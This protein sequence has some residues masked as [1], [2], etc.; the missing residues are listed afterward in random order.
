M[1][2]DSVYQNENCFI[3]ISSSFDAYLASYK[4]ENLIN[5]TASD[6]VNLVKSGTFLT[7]EWLSM[8]M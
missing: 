1:N 2:V 7:H 6:A 3:I 4:T 8:E 5:I